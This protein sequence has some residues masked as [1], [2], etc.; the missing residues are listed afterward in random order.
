MLRLLMYVNIYLNTPSH[1]NGK[2]HLASGSTSEPATHFGV[3]VCFERGLIFFRFRESGL[4]FPRS[5]E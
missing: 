3:G 5:R 4:S 1:G 2:Q